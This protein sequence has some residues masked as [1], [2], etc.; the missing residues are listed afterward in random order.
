MDVRRLRV[1]EWLAGIGGAALLVSLFLDWYGG[2]TGWRSFSV[3]DVLLALAG[4]LAVGLAA[5]TAA[6]KAGAVPIALASL[7]GSASMVSLLLVVWRVLDPPGTEGGRDA[8]LWIGLAACAAM[9]AGAFAAM[10]DERY[11]EAARSNVPIE[12]LTPPESGPA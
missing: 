6:H 8:G 12:N 2:A 7:L 1:G 3:V 9:V 5:V 4:V 10:K 11:P